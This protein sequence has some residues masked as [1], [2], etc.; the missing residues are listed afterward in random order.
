M[1]DRSMSALRFAFVLVL[2][3]ALVAGVGVAA[4][5]IKSGPQVGKAVPGPFHPLNVTGAKAGEKFC[6]YCCNGNNPVAMVFARDVNAPVAKL[7]KKIDEATEKNKS[8]HMGSFVVFLS[9]NEKLKTQLK[10]LADKENIR[11]TV[12]A[13]DNPAGPQNYNVEKDADV[14]VVLYTNHTVKA[15]HAFRKGELKDPDIDR[16]VADVSKIVER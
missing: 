1:E 10:D 2:G 11:N 16:I 7:I 9:D 15:N 14:T 5:N 8:A 3:L 13:I 4:E 6:L 12:L